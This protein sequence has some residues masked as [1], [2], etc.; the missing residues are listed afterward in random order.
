M[1]R[2][3]VVK[4]SPQIKLFLDPDLLTNGFDI[5]HLLAELKLELHA[6]A[7]SAGAILLLNIIEA[8]VRQLVGNR[9]ERTGEH[10]YWGSQPGCIHVGGQKVRIARPRV[11]TGRG[12]GKEVIPSSYQRFQ[13][14]NDRTNRVF[15]EAMASVSCRQYPEAIEKLCAGYGISKSVVSR[16]LVRATTKELDALCQR[17]LEDFDLAILII[18]GI[19]MDE[20][21][22]VCALGVDGKGKKRFL[23]FLEGATENTEVCK[24]LLENLRERG[25]KL[26]QPLLAVLDGAK[27]LTK[28]VR[29]VCGG[30]VA[31]QRC[32]EHKIRNVKSHLP[33][34]HQQRIIGKIRAAYRTKDY[35]EAKAALQSVVRELDRIN[36]TA[37]RSL[38]EGIEQTL[39]VHRLGLPD[40]LRRSFAS[41]NTIESAYSRSRWVMRNVKRWTTNNQKHRWLATALLRAEKSFRRI[42]GYEAMAYL[43]VGLASY[44]A[45]QQNK[46]KAA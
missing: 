44:I 37:A 18:D 45:E 43:K 30:T 33:K 28:A 41:T 32:Q 7:T 23:G 16:E 27:A 21:V 4:P 39:T 14:N 15:A 19:E 38:E 36:E 34:Q 40:I 25:L 29:H 26:D 42:K 9:Y 10:Y 1:S 31:I 2:R 3:N 6:R 13:E 8:E 5:D 35:G 20:S 11:R 46:Q 22:F 12:K 17:S 24:Q